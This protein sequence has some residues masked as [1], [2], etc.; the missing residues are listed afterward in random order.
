RIRQ[1]GEIAILAA[2]YVVTAWLSFRFHV[3]NGLESLIWVPTGIGFAAVLVRGNRMALGIALGVVVSMAVSIH[4]VFAGVG[5]GTVE[6]LAA[7]GG[8]CLLRRAFGFRTALARVRDVFAF[9]GAS[10][11]LSLVTAALDSGVL[12]AAGV[13]EPDHFASVVSTWWWGYLA[14]NLIVAPLVLTWG[15]RA[16]ELLHGRRVRV[17]EVVAF[18]VGV[19][20][21]CTYVFYHWGPE[22]LPGSRMPYLLVVFLLWAG[23]RFGP[24]GAAATSFAI[25]AVAILA[26]TAGSGPFAQLP[27]YLQVFVSVSALMTLVLG[28][29]QVERLGAVQR[30]GAILAGALDA[31]I[32]I[33]RDAR[34]VE[35]NPAA[36]NL[37]GVRAKDCIG[38]DV[39]P[40]VIPP[41][42]HGRFRA[43]LASYLQTGA[44]ELLGR[45]DRLRLCRADGTEFT[46]EITAMRVPI[47]GQ[48]LF[49]AFI[50]DITTEHAAEVAL[51]ES[52]RL[53]EER[54]RERTVELVVANQELK[55]RDELLRD[56]QALSNVGSFERDLDHD[57]LVWSDEMYRIYGRDPATFDPKEGFV[58]CVHPDDRPRLQAAMDRARANHESFNFEMRIVRPDGEIRILHSRGRTYVDESDRAL[59]ITGYSQ[60]ITERKLAEE[61]RYRLGEIVESSE[62]AIIGISRD[63]AIESWNRAAE[64][65]FG[66]TAAEVSG[67]PATLLVP[68]GHS[69]ELEQLLESVRGGQHLKHYNLVHA[70]RDGTL[71]EASVTTS[72]IVDGDGRV[73]GMSKVVRDISD[74]KAA[75]D[76]IRAALREKEV[77]L[78]EIHHRV[79]NNLQVISSLLNLQLSPMPVGDARKALLESQSRIQSMA[80]VH[81]LL[82]RSKDLA[83]ID[84]LE[85]LQNLMTRLGQA[86]EVDAHRQIETIVR[87]PSI[88]LDVDRAI[89]CGLI[90]NELVANAFNHAFPDGRPGRIWVTLTQQGDQLA[91]EVRDDGIG[92]P[93][94]LDIDTA[95]TFGLQIVRTL[96]HQ[97]ESTIELVCDHGT[98][99]R[100]VFPFAAQPAASTVAEPRTDAP[101]PQSTAIH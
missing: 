18:G 44:S 76:Q 87:A 19:I 22:L 101:Q 91:L 100:V 3:V 42:M 43:D 85:Y 88:R 40:L 4:S 67:R 9:V 75:E 14:A 64:A 82:Y 96:A 74:Q 80:L 20:L 39:V 61:A 71:F 51:H 31:I 47:E 13:V 23:L 55:R 79:K 53:L 2:V 41:R 62:D 1:L 30:K 12:V 58:S 5:V 84:L 46:A 97:L 7:I 36:E 38:K 25:T 21:V 15:T 8:A 93:P 27:H 33:D 6:A 11:V 60:D 94:G 70:R 35:F 50:R 17:P 10:I 16:P 49:T 90:V 37:I 59:R 29:M 83:H 92:I 54:V 77:L 56:S 57:V 95:Q 72:A 86:Y 99:V 65:I 73:I 89:P 69:R 98:T 78:R 24:R 34:I 28:A 45:R 48:Y 26:T 68:P 32:T 52:Q 63:G 81:Q 66:Y